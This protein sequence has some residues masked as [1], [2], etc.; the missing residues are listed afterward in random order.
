MNVIRKIL[1]RIISVI[2]YIIGALLL[3]VVLLPGSGSMTYGPMVLVVMLFFVAMSVL[4][5]WGGNKL[6][7]ISCKKKLSPEESED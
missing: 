6:W 2:L 5:F 7:K 3:I 4:L 1:L